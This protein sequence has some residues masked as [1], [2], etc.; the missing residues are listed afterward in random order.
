MHSLT[1]KYE[2]DEE[3]GAAIQACGSG[4][5]SDALHK[6]SIAG[7]ADLGFLE[8]IL[9]PV[10]RFFTLSLDLQDSTVDCLWSISLPHH[11][12]PTAIENWP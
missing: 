11:D 3:S 8:T 9:R 7:Q 2:M 5:G 6:L 4:L 12:H 10:F 1:D